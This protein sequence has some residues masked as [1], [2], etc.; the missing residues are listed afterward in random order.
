[1]T[2]MTPSSLHISTSSFQGSST[3]G[4]EAM[5]SIIATTFLPLLRDKLFKCA[6]K[7]SI[8]IEGVVGKVI[9]NPDCVMCGFTS[10]RCW[11]VLAI[12]L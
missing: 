6:L 9:A 1:M 8:M 2:L 5:E 4:H 11:T 3:P 12:A 7:S 10:T